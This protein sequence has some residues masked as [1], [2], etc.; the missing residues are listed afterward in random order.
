MNS[1]QFNHAS[2]EFIKFIHDKTTDKT[3]K[4]ITHTIMPNNCGV[5][6]LKLHIDDASSNRFFQLMSTEIC[7]NVPLSVVER[8][9]EFGPIIYD[10]DLKYD[11]TK[12]QKLQGKRICNLEFINTFIA[13]AYTEIGKC[14]DISD[15]PYANHCYILT[16]ERATKKE[17]KKS[18]ENANDTTKE[19]EYKDGLHIFFPN[20]ITYPDIQLCIRN[21]LVGEMEVTFN[22]MGLLNTADDI[23][24]ECVIE[25]NGFMMY[26]NNKLGGYPYLV[27]SDVKD[28]S[29]LY[30]A[31]IAEQHVTINAHEDFVKPHGQGYYKQVL[32]RKL[33]IREANIL[34]VAKITD[35]GKQYLKEQHNRNKQREVNKLKE[36]HNLKKNLQDGVIIQTDEVFQ[37]ACGLVD[38]LSEKRAE[39]EPSWIDVGWTLYNIDYRLL[40]KWIEFSQKCPRYEVTAP[41]ECSRI[42]DTQIKP[43]SKSI[44][45]LVYYAKKDNPELFE[46]YHHRDSLN[47]MV[48]KTLDACHGSFYLV[49]DEKKKS[50]KPE[51]SKIFRKFDNCADYICDIMYHCFGDQFVCSSYE[52]KQWYRFDGVR[53]ELTDKG[54]QIQDLLKDDMT[55]FFRDYTSQYEEYLR[56]CIH[57]KNTY[58]Y[59][60]MEIYKKT[61]EYIGT[62]LHTLKGRNSILESAAQKFHWKSNHQH[63]YKRVYAFE[64]ILDYNIYTIGMNNGIYDLKT[65][66]FRE[67]L[68]EDYLEKSTNIDYIE[69]T[70]ESEPVKYLMKVLRQILPDEELFIFTMCSLAKSCDGDI[71]RELFYICS[72]SGGNGKSKLFSA[73][74]LAMGQYAHFG[75][76]TMF[77][78][79]RAQSSNATPD[80]Y[81]LKGKRIA[82]ISEPG[83]DEKFNVGIMKELT[84]GEKI[85]CRNLNQ[86]SITYLPQFTF[87]LQCNTK[88]SIPAGDG[89]TSRR[90]C[91]I[92]FES[93]FTD[94]PNPNKKYKFAKDLKL[95][96]K[97]EKYKEAFFWILMQYY[98]IAEKGDPSYVWKKLKNEDGTPKVGIAPHIPIPKRVIETNKRYEQQHDPIGRFLSTAIVQDE[99]SATYIAYLDDLFNLY[100]FSKRVQNDLQNV[101]NKS[102][103]L[104]YLEKDKCLGPMTERGGWKGIRVL[105]VSDIPDCDKYFNDTTSPL[106]ADYL[107]TLT[108]ANST[109]ASATV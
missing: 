33:S 8:H 50:Y 53:W 35:R 46:Q 95:S 106:K 58:R 31:N 87:W 15:I 99:R 57:E 23:I 92:D 64:E 73:V 52:K 36:S 45:T 49:W 5:P 74:S 6:C 11:E 79:K 82:I 32:L 29:G 88:P 97:I 91:N 20:I 41:I 89:G 72:G 70:W 7:N 98:K 56:L 80:L 24:D 4:F 54:V 96:E 60:K 69:Y 43:S 108:N 22:E 100:K 44:G 71:G 66:Q 51:G 3:G 61:C 26:A 40:D 62:Q 77:T 85:T 48:K 67:A 86:G 28:V 16:K 93:E 19:Y 13:K 34:D 101:G 68:P 37:Y 2:S 12:N 94:N 55:I 90:L 17:I 83:E 75:Q 81:D 9:K 109:S 14:I 84:G 65:N 18:V 104:N 107:N 105:P 59:A 76:I 102:T 103:F 47:K 39:E 10:L 63:P 21:N 78:G 38:L 30:L 25:K 42:W 27:Q 1:N